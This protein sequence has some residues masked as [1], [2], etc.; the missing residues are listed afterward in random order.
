MLKLNARLSFRKQDQFNKESQQTQQ[1]EDGDANGGEVIQEK[2]E[3]E[4]ENEIKSEIQTE[5]GLKYSLK[6]VI[7]H[8]GTHNYGHYIA[9]RKYR[10]IWWRI[11]DETVRVSEE[12]EV[13]SSQGTFMLFYEL[14][15][16]NDPRDEID[17]SKLNIENIPE[18]TPEEDENERL[19]NNDDDSDISS[20]GPDID[21]G[22]VEE[23][24]DDSHDKSEEEEEEGEEET[25]RKQSQL[26][27]DDIQTQLINQ[28]GLN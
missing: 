13:L 27:Y 20:S 6:S 21:E 10:G 28:Q 17:I 12:R 8:Y 25:D 19:N 22:E 7:S 23:I 11:S 2:H 5:N 18:S 4:E 1:S 16:R 14:S 9:F 3:A 15:S 24:D 26:D